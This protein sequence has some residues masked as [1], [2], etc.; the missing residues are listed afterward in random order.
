[1]RYKFTPF[2]QIEN[3]YSSIIN[4]ASTLARINKFL[5]ERG[6]EEAKERQDSS[7]RNFDLLSIPQGLA[8]AEVAPTGQSQAS[9]LRREFEILKSELTVAM[10]GNPAAYGWKT[11]SQCD[12][13]GIIR[14]CLNRIS[15]ST[16]LSRTF[17]E[18]GC[19]DGLEN[20]THQLAL[21][22]FA[23]YWVDGDSA[24]IRFVEEQLGGAVFPG[25]RVQEAFV[26]LSSMPSI[27]KNACSFLGTEDI[28]FFSLDVDGNDAHLVRETLGLIRPKLLCVEYNA[29]FR[30][31]TRTE[32]DYADSHRWSGDDYFGASLQTWVDTLDGY[33]LVACNLSGANAFFVRSD[34]A[35]AFRL[36]TIAQLYQP[37]RYWLAGN[38]EGHPASLRWLRQVVRENRIERP[39]LIEAEVRGL[40]TFDFE[41][42][43]RTDQY[44]SENLARNSIWE[45]FETE[46]FCRLCQSGDFV[47]DIGGNIGWYSVLASKLVGPIGRLLTFEPDPAN[48]ALL[49]RNVARCGDRPTTDLRQEAVGETPSKVKLFRSSTNLGDHRLFDDGTERGS[50]EVPLQTLDSMLV[51]EARWPDIV[52]SD[53]QGSEARILRG[54]R[55]TLSRGW[56]P[57]FLLEFWPF[58][59]TGSGSDPLALWTEL[60]ALGYKMYEVSEANPRL[61]TLAESRMMMRLSTDI[62]VESGGFINILAIPE[63]SSRRALIGDLID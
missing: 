16:V 59:L 5:E 31:P 36:F 60:L 3:I 10:P 58:G 61:T 41:I 26:T 2:R 51:G 42:H 63:G 9:A 47:L 48:F 35:G 1:M 30:P 23:G 39:W 28:D 24:K 40:P 18:I 13:D 53:T 4:S 56:R 55:A 15:Q 14:E 45:P 54:A 19:A 62:T 49:S 7:K 46:V 57:I 12:E 29:K 37:P 52:K 44:I 43:R 8:F 27:V 6:S 17:I 33:C 22:G 38:V 32:M 20:N 11:Y 34:L 21:D 25:L 50:I